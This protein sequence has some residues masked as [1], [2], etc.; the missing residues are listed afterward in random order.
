MRS[1]ATVLLYHGIGPCP[2]G[3]QAHLCA[4]IGPAVF[5]RQM[6]F[7]SRHRRVIPLADLLAEPHG[8]ASGPPTVAL[9][10]DDGL[11]SV[12]TEALPVL[13]RLMLPATVFVPT[14]WIGRANG[15]MAGSRCYPLPLMTED[16]LRE[17]DRAGISVE[18]HGHKHI[19]M[20]AVP[21]GVVRDDLRA[22]G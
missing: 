17:V 13:R 12:L 14:R 22:S 1:R 19:D 6:D 2:S 4:N 9:T 8:P 11:R 20:S 15:W 21:E 10:F 3:S 18:S 7:L 5:A 16:E